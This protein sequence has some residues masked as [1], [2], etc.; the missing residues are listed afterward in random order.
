MVSG[1]VPPFLSLNVADK[2]DEESQRLKAV[3]CGS[4]LVA[5]HA[6]EVL[7]SPDDAAAVAAVPV[8][9][10]FIDTNSWDC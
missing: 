10:Q 4:G 2:M 7:D 5:K 9:R 6:G 1:N 8:R 3:L